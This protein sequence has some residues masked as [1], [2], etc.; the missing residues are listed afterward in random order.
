MSAMCCAFWLW[1]RALRSPPSSVMP[2]AFLGGLAYTWM[3]ASWGGYVFVINVIGAHALCL[4]GRDML[5]EEKSAV[6]RAY[7]TFFVVGTTG[8]LHVPPVGMAPLRSSEQLLPLAVFAALQLR[9]ANAFLR[10]ATGTAGAVAWKAWLPLGLGALLA[11]AT[12][13]ELDPTLDP[14]ALVSPLSGRVRALFGQSAV[15]TG[16]PL[17]DSV[18]EHQPS[19]VEAYWQMT[20]TAP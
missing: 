20:S 7:S 14:A 1:C 9:T 11:T 12:A 10:R 18:A 4:L 3:V 2:T 16:N 15:E 8:A 6:Y 5:L 19:E 17:V 13:M